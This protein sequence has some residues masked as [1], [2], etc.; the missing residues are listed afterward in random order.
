MGTLLN[1]TIASTYESLLKVGQGS[2]ADNINITG[3]LTTIADGLDNATPISLATGKMRVTLGTSDGNDF[4]VVDTSGQAI[5]KVKG[6]TDDVYID[7]ATD[8][9][10]IFPKDRSKVYF[11]ADSEVILEHSNNE[12]LFLNS[13]MKLAFRDMGG[14]YVKSVSDGNLGLYAGTSLDLVSS[15]IDIGLDTSADTTINILGTND[16][17]IVYDTSAT[18]LNFDSN[19]LVV[20]G[21]NDRIGIGTASPNVNLDI[22]STTTSSTL[23][24]IRSKNSNA[25]ADACVRF[26]HG[27]TPDLEGGVGFNAGTSTMFLTAGGMDNQHLAIDSA[28]QVG[29]GITNPGYALHVKTASGNAEIYLEAD[30]NDARFS[31][32]TGGND[33]ASYIYFRDE[34]D[35]NNAIVSFNENYGTASMQS[36]IGFYTDAQTDSFSATSPK[37]LIDKDG[38]VGIGT[39][40]PSSPLSVEANIA[41]TEVLAHFF[42]G[43]MANTDYFTINIGKDATNHDCG[44]LKF[45]HTA[46]G[47]TQ[48]YISLGLKSTEDTLAVNSNGRVGIGTASPD[49][50]LH[51]KGT[52]VIRSTIESSDGDTELRLNSYSGT[53]E[54]GSCFIYFDSSSSA[55]THEGMIRYNH[56]SVAAN[57]NMRFYTGDSTTLA[58][59]I[60]GNG[61]VGIG[62][63]SPGKKLEVDE[64]NADADS[65]GVATVSKFRGGADDG[66]GT[67]YY[68]TCED[69]NGDDV[70]YIQNVSGTFSTPDS[71]DRRI[72]KDI[73]DT[74]RTGLSAIKR[75]QVRDF[76]YKKNNIQQTGLIAQEVKEVWEDVV[77]GE[78]DAVKENGS[79]KPMAI[80]YSHLVIPLILAVQELSAK[81]EALE[82]K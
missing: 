79:V 33:K 19:T 59:T 8:A 64:S 18:L 10:L 66:G 53:G 50:L 45:Y 4:E 1:K 61:N 12:G 68:M 13:G 74:S 34:G 35:I 60:L 52:G 32:D 78:P 21:A 80:A 46:D 48:N 73:V 65:S 63:S 24:D 23:L 81:V 30:G 49:D 3:T 15:Q 55:S 11:G 71:S 76:K 14:E 27:S 42:D 36:S 77:S 9:R 44:V 72:K 56:S 54:T 39:A 16:F 38:K 25:A 41:D 37:L 40:S 29:I 31:M 82:N 6:D 7:G 70:G 20:D 67:V 75:L 51:V 26:F 57:Q 58:M 62:E 5:L 69:G 22:E 28:G 2:D 43:T 17:A 47:H